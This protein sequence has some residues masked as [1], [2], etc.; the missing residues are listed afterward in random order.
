MAHY[1]EG[2]ALEE[3]DSFSYL[4]STLGQTARVDK[5]VAIRLEKAGTVYQMWRRKVFGSRNLGKATKLHAFQSLVVSVL[6]YGAETWP[7][8][9]QNITRLKIFQMR[10][11]RDIIGVTLWDKRRNVDILE[12]TGQLP[13]EEQVRKKRL[14]WFGHLHVQ[15]MPDH[16]P[17][18]QLLKCRPKGKRRKPG[19]T[20]LRWV[21]AINRD[22][23]RVANWQQLVKDR[24]T[25][26]E[27]VHQHAPLPQP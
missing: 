4:G 2:Q 20:S 17:Q 12:E 10:C 27:V 22:L 3:V 19:G 11:L 25:W 23:S 5:E 26:Q 24:R 1:I 7:V 8:N 14:Q 16:R 21:D 6:L 15:R 9:Q 18:K 13:I